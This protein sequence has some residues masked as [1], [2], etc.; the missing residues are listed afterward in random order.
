MP[1]QLFSDR[2]VLDL[3]TVGVSSLD[4]FY[5]LCHANPDIP[6]E[7]NAQGEI[8]IMSPVNF[9]GNGQETALSSELYQ[10]NKLAGLGVVRSSSVGITLPN[11]AVRSPDALWISNE[12]VLMLSKTEK[13]RFPVLVPD[14]VAEIRSIT[15]RLAHLQAKMTEYLESGVRLGW[16]LDPTDKKAYIYC[17]GKPVQPIVLAPETH[18]S[19]EEVLPG[20]V[21]EASLLF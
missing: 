9:D 13:Q 2:M 10:W 3:S 11:G 16:L 15:D 6:F 18:L 14:F 20:F 19:G 1:S 17:L 8:E 4:D 12:K 5:E 21:F 7:R